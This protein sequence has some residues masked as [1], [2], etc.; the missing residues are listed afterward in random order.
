MRI[1]CSLVDHMNVNLGAPYE[2]IIQKFI[3]RGYASSKTEVLRQALKAYDLDDQGFEGQEIG[4]RKM[5]EE[6]TRLVGKA[7]EHEMKRIREGKAK[8]YSW[9]EVKKELKIK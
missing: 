7:V 4:P 3:K 8:T 1:K 2:A 9:E 6:E 5:G